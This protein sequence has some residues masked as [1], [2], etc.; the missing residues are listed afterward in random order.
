MVITI[1][2]NASKQI[3][4]MMK[5]ETEGAHLRFG[6]KGGGCSGLSYSLGFEY[7]INEELD[8]V[9]EI[10]GIP[11]VFFNQDI[12]ILEGTTI[13]FKQNM[14]GGGFSIDNPN[15]IVSCGC[16]SS[17]RAKDREGVPENC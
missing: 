10:N 8:S 15:A 16:G 12:P 2:D 6:I 11:V 14:M 5:E 3:Q 7:N 13:D 4:E 9:E 17:F 1:T